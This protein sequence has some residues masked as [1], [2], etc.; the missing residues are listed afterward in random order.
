MLFLCFLVSFSEQNPLDVIDREEAGYYRIFTDIDSFALAEFYE[1]GDSVQ[2]RILYTSNGDTL[3]SVVNIEKSIYNAL[4]FYCANFQK[5]ITDNTFRE[6]FVEN[7]SVAWPVITEKEI[8]EQGRGVKE[9]SCLN[10][11]CCITGTAATGAYIGALSG[12]EVYKVQTGIPCGHPEYGYCVI[13]FEYYVYRIKPTNFWTGTAIGTA[14][15][16]VMSKKLYYKKTE[17][18]AVLNA[19]AHDIVAFDFAGNPITYS[20]IQKENERKYRVMLGALGI[21]GGIGGSLLTSYGLVQ[22]YLGLNAE[23]EWD[24]YAAVVPILIISQISFYQIAKF[25]IEKGEELDRLA[26]I[27]KI[28]KRR[29]AER[30][31]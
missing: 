16:F 15:G 31:K 8:K 29:A 9:K 3:D 2:V 14:T 4:K 26:T 5:I 10:S 11:F 24:E 23:K 20:D 28:K 19:L 30:Q 22:P 25:A 1:D 6:H 13:P 12:M 17:K 7:F 27:E 21:I 18:V